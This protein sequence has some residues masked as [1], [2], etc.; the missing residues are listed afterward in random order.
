MNQYIDLAYIDLA[1]FSPNL[2]Y[3]RG[4]GLSRHERLEYP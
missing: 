2:G 3:E 4:M 1:D